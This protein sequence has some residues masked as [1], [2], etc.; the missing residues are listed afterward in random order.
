MDNQ[1]VKSSL[2]AYVPDNEKP[3][4]CNHFFLSLHDADY[5]SW[6]IKSRVHLKLDLI[7]E[8]AIASTRG[9]VKALALC[10]VDHTLK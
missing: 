8:T 9:V 5:Q 1:F 2:P 6:R 3:R 10:V 7:V 4:Q